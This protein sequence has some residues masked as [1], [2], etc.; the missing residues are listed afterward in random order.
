[1]HIKVTDNEELVAEI[2]QK[3]QENGN[4]CPSKSEKS[5]E[6]KCICKEFIDLPETGVCRCGLYRKLEV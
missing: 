6:T 1:M 4:Y 5:P 3:L 2:R